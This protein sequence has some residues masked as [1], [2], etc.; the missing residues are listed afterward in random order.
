MTD[1]HLGNETTNPAD[2]Q[3][4]AARTN[5]GGAGERA[6]QANAGELEGGALNETAFVGGIMAAAGDALG[7]NNIAFTGFQAAAPAAAAASQQT[8]V[9]ED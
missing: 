1:T 6:A 2:D 7:G 3:P 9:T 8:D 4:Q 5:P